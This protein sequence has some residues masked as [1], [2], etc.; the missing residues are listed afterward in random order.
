MPGTLIA[1]AT[2]FL[3]LRCTGSGT[4]PPRSAT[5]IVLRSRYDMSGTDLAYATTRM[6]TSRLKLAVI[7]AHAYAMS[8]TDL[9]FRTTCPCDVR[10]CPSVWLYQPTSLLRDA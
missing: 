8:G 9:V 6:T 5:A 1:Y 4:N 7:F 2:T 3:S 10:Y